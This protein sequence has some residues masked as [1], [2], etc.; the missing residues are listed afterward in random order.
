MGFRSVYQSL[1]ELFPQI[2]PKILRGVAIEHQHDADEAASVVISEIFPFSSPNSTQPHNKNKTKVSDNPPNLKVKCDDGSLSLSQWLQPSKL[3]HSYLALLNEDSTPDVKPPLDYVVEKVV[4]PSRGPATG[5][6]G[7]IRTMY[8]SDNIGGSSL[9]KPSIRVQSR[10]NNELSGSSSKVPGRRRSSRK[11]VQPWSPDYSEK[12]RSWK[13]R[14]NN[15]NRDFSQLFDNDIDVPSTRS[16]KCYTN[17]RERKQRIADNIKALG[18]LLPHKVEGDNHELTLNAMVDHVKLLHLQMK[19]LSRSRL[20]GEPI[21]HPMAFIEG[22]GHYIHHEQ[23]MAKSLEEVME[24]LLTKDFDAAA[25]L[26]E[27]KGLYLTPL[28]SVQGSC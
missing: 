4:L 25:N 10:T 21:S 20:G 5:L 7:G 16:N 9:V 15:N 22:Y 14:S 26:L 11:S 28:S 12:L 19:E 17:E 24:D 27:S 18:K 1:T 2:D 13:K 23:T 6:G 3:P 8:S